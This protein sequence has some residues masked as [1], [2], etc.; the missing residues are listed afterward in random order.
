MRSGGTPAL[1]T[2]A[3]RVAENE[4]ASSPSLTQN[5]S[6]VPGCTVVEIAS[7]AIETA[8]TSSSD[9]NGS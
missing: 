2:L 1:M 3:A 4:I 8:V 7:F 5:A 6:G 9:M